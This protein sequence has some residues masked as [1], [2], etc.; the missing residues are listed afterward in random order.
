MI[1]C[2]IDYS[3]SSPAV[4]VHTGIGKEFTPSTCKFL[5]IPSF[6]KRTPFE[7]VYGNA[8]YYMVENMGAKV[9]GIERMTYLAETCESFI[10]LHGAESYCI[11]GYSFSGNG[12]VF[13]LG[14]NAGILKSQLFKNSIAQSGTPSPGEVKKFAFDNAKGKGA[15][16]KHQMVDRFHA[17]VGINLYDLF[18]LPFCP[19][20]H[21]MDKIPSPIDDIADAYFICKMHHKILS[22]SEN[23]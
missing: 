7:P 16:K 21:S 5:A 20:K 3:I 14:E 15:A 22:E 1:S 23:I 4:C 12:Q 8:Q 6:K 10:T 19:I 11:E 18:E 13:Q 17:E 9:F 2:G